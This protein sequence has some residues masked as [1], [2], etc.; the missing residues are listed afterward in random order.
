MVYNWR[1]ARQD[2]DSCMQYACMNAQ[3]LKLITD[4]FVPFN[5]HEFHF[6]FGW[7]ALGYYIGKGIRGGSRGMMGIEGFGESRRQEGA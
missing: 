2:Q 5:S 7:H 4:G 1:L 3:G 6:V